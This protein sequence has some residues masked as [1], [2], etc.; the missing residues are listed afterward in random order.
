MKEST[1]THFIVWLCA[2]LLFVVATAHPVPKFPSKYTFRG[3][4][5]LPFGNITEPLYVVNDMDNNRQFVDFYNGLDYNVYRYDK[6]YM[7][8]IYMA[9]YNHRCAR[10]PGSGRVMDFIPDLS[11]GFEYKGQSTVDGKLCEWWQQRIVNGTKANTYDFYYT[12]RGNVPVKYQLMGYDTIFGSHYDLYILDF[13]QFSPFANET[14]FNTPQICKDSDDIE[15][16]LRVRHR[17]SH[18]F[19]RMPCSEDNVDCHMYKFEHKFKRHY[20]SHKEYKNARLNLQNN[21]EFIQQHNANTNNLFQVD[22]NQFSDSPKR[23]STLLP[24][25]MLSPHRDTSGKGEL[26]RSQNVRV[27]ASVD[28]REKGAVSHIKDQGACGS[29]WSFSTTG[30]I[31]GQYALKTGHLKTFSEQNIVD[32]A[33]NGNQGCDGGFQHFAYQYIMENGGL[34][35]DSA[36][37]YIMQNGYC[38]YASRESNV[39]VK[40]Y[41]K[42]P[43]GDEKALAEAVATIG[44]I[45]VSIDASHPSLLFYSSGVYYEPECGNTPDDLD[46]AVLVVGYGTTPQGEDYWIVK[47]SWSTNWG[48]EGY[49]LMARNR[50]NNCGI[51]TGASYPVLDL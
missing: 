33:W 16:A 9:K 32:C 30:T 46:H 20:N 23:L 37:P 48:D 4:F 14:A 13:H 10:I 22:L 25:G 31:E 1:C 27:P 43:E 26:F 12:K 3:T 39:K 28:W 6:G 29:C 17:L 2:A 38:H 5:S 24:K 19:T 41:V 45:S 47:N 51:A 49:V 34:E 11:Q 8:E 40:S 44:P 21:L 35:T 7:Y 36:Y 15:D 42:I 18:H 50:N